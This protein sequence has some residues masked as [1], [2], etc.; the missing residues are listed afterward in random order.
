MLQGCMSYV[1]SDLTRVFTGDALLIRGC[2]RTDF[3][4]EIHCFLTLLLCA[5][6]TNF[7]LLLL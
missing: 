1:L 6:L 4:V 5:Y 7:S 2:G 3:Q